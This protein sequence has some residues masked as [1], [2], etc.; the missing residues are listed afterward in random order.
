MT[1][2]PSPPNHHAQ[3]FPL[4]KGQ[5]W[6]FMHFFLHPQFFPHP[7]LHEHPLPIFT[8]LFEPISCSWYLEY[9]ILFWSID[10]YLMFNT[11]FYA[12]WSSVWI[13]T[14]CLLLQQPDTCY[15]GPS[16][17][18]LFRH[19]ADSKPRSHLYF[20]WLCKLWQRDLQSMVM[21]TVI[22]L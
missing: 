18:P 22:Y 8:G 12:F 20:H 7:F 4:Q 9:A 5:L 11:K 19:H 17:H 10:L 2:S 3:L 6:H 14:I 1:N 16:S 15:M 21:G 13:G